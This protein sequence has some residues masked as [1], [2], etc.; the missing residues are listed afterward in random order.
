MKAITRDFSSGIFIKRKY[1][2][3]GSEN[4]RRQVGHMARK[5]ITKATCYLII[6]FAD[7]GSKII[8]RNSLQ[9]RTAPLKVRNGMFVRRFEEC[10]KHRAEVRQ[11]IKIEMSLS[12]FSVPP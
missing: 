4:S 9:Y 2:V 11:V 12:N 10:S 5:L 1:D 6:E 7:L 8:H 3:E